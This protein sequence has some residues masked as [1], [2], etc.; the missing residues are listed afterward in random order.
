MKKYFLFICMAI[1]VWSCQQENVIQSNSP[2]LL[3]NAKTACLTLKKNFSSAFVK[4]LSTNE[5][6]RTLIKNEALKQFDFDY[7]V[8]YQLIKDEK[9]KSGKSLEELLSKYLSREELEKINKELPTLTIFVP[10]LPEGSFSAE[11]WD[12]IN[13]KP[14]VAVKVSEPCNV[15][16]YYP[17]GEEEILPSGVIPGFP[18]VTI[19]ENDRVV[20][21][22]PLTRSI[23]GN[24]I[25]NKTNGSN[26]KFINNIFDNSNNFPTK[27]TSNRELTTTRNRPSAVETDQFTAYP[28]ET[29]KNYLKDNMKRIIEA[30]DVYPDNTGWQRDYVYYNISPTQDRGAFNYNYK[31]HLVGFK[32]VGDGLGVY[33]KI[34]DQNEDPKVNFDK[35]YISSS[36]IRLAPD[37]TDGEY[38]FQVLTYVGNKSAVGNEFRTMFRAKPTDLF[39]AVFKKT[40]GRPGTT[41][42]VLENLTSLLYQLSLP[43]FEWNIKDY[44]STIKI[45]I[46]EIDG[47]ETQ[48][49]TTTTSTEFAT[50]FSF[51]SN[52][53][54]TVKVG[55]K[56]G[57]STKETKTISYQVT[58]SLGNDL[59]G[60][61]IINFADPII[62]NKDLFV[63][64]KPQVG[65]RPG[66]AIP[67]YS[68]PGSYNSKYSTGWYQ[69][70][71]APLKTN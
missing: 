23:K 70:F 39:K 16:V 57:T 41:Q 31:E 30:Y 56:F 19:K 34:S 26:F 4:V 58:K 27:N 2:N 55:E 28:Y 12:I 11:N 63:V 1:I 44:S 43:L 42:F 20:P 33:N 71:I 51:D 10:S 3:E 15:L 17:S 45:A 52:Y 37:W 29:Y 6:V 38:E 36:T 49:L 64:W 60:E 69:L 21:N 24:T 67:D 25:A 22:N 62:T 53:G 47:V 35:T 13:E 65:T 54:E 66:Q 61:V 14:A 32:L 46:E 7:D 68:F 48:V 5:E 59:L 18:I 50:N 9:L 40:S 8:L